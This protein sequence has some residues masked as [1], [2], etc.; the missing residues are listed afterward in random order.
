VD[1][2]EFWARIEGQLVKC[3][4]FVMRLSCSGRPFHAAFTTQGQETLQGH[5]LAFNHFGGV[6][7][8]IRYD[9]LKPAVIKVLKGRNRT[10]SERFIALRSHYGFDSFFCRPGKDGA[11]EK[12]GVEGDIG[13]FRRRHLV[14]IPD[15]GSL[16][17]LNT[18]SLPVICLT[19]P[20]LSRGGLIRWPRR[21]PPNYPPCSRFPTRHS[22]RRWFCASEL[23]CGLG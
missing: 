11:H 13:R 10:E 4:M 5:V 1:F 23:I 6:P 16:A 17:E 22:I 2:G 7:G 20:A 15:V 18:I 14:P 8:R 9:N 19:T 21:S 12:G 3:W